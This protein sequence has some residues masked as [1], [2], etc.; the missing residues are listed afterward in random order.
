MSFHK[1]IKYGKEHRKPYRGAKSFDYS[2]HN[3]GSCPYCTNGRQHFD[4]KRRTVADEKL[5]KWELELLEDEMSEFRGDYPLYVGDIVMD[6]STDLFNLTIVNIS[7]DGIAYC[8]D[9]NGQEYGIPIEF[10]EIQE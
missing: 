4:R 8:E 3:H 1:A 2:C 6:T 7:H 5:H 10:L 9:E